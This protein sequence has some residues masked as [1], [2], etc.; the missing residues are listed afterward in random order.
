[1]IVD[2]NLH[3]KCVIVV[4]G[5]TE[6]VRKVRGLLGQN[7]KIIVISNRINRHLLN[8]SKGG[9]IQVVKTKLKDA[10]ILSNY[11]N[12]FLILAATN[13]KLLNRKLVDKGRQMGSFVYAADDP[14]YSDFSYASIINIEGTMQVAISTSGKSPIMARKVRIKA[15]RILRK[16]IT[17]SDIENT[18][19]QDFARNAAK[20]KIKT[21]GKRKEFLY[22]IINDQ[23]IQNLIKEERFEDAK[24]ITLKLLEKWENKN[25]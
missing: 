23:T 6:G 8:L 24:S 12:P 22:S 7:C 10:D 17:R 3:G 14:S 20:L 16:V 21:V 4:G 13:D 1:M 11:K 25:N 15:E 19:L 9:E 2:L 18:K 5:G